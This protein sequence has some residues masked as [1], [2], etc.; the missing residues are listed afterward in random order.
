[1]VELTDKEC[2]ALTEL[3]AD[4]LVSPTWLAQPYAAVLNSAHKRLTGEDHPN[5]IWY[6]ENRS[7]VSGEYWE[8][9][10]RDHPTPALTD[11]EIHGAT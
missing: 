7:P 10:E 1:M 6:Q 3:I 2:D 8:D 11:E 9:P 4:R 5:W